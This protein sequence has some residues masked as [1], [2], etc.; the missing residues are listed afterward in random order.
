MSLSKSVCGIFKRNCLGI[1]K[2]LP[3]TQSPLVFKPEV[4]GTYL[5]VTGILG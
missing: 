1:L 5:P 4:M 2:F 3:S